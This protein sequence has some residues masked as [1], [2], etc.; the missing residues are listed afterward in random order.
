MERFLSKR[1]IFLA[2]T[3]ILF[4]TAWNRGI[5]LLYLM[6]S[7]LLATLLLGHLLPQMVLG[8]IDVERL[9]PKVAVAGD[10]VRLSF[11][12]RNRG[13]FPRFMVE[14]IDTFPCGEYGKTEPML[15][16]S[17]L[18]PRSEVNRELHIP[19]AVR[20]EYMLGP[21]QVASAFPLGLARRQKTI[22]GHSPRILV[23]PATFPIP[24]IPI[25]P[26]SAKH[27]E[28]GES[29]SIAG[30]SEEFFGIREYR[31]GDSIRMV[32]WPSSARRNQLLV[33]EMEVRVSAQVT[34][35]LDLNTLAHA[36]K[37][38]AHS[39]E[40]VIK[41][42]ASICLHTLERHHQVQLMSYGERLHLS[43][44]RSGKEHLQELMTML[45]KVKIGQMPFLQLI[46][47]AD[48]VMQD[49]Q[50]VILVCSGRSLD[51]LQM[52]QALAL[53]Q[54]KRMQSIVVMV[55]TDGFGG[56]DY[57]NLQTVLTSSTTRFYRMGKDDSFTTL[58]AINGMK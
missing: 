32:H 34:L 2:L 40:Y 29:L 13:F 7:L 17:S 22:A 56:S 16:V 14:V 21:L 30:G 50:S 24:D 57:S 25:K 33:K 44:C 55:E 15:F 37:G 9:A 52:R 3:I 4:L 43:P 12:L 47:R 19:C 38:S 23:Y 45:A 42:A 27:R 46:Q 5:P 53:L 54:A 58:F 36:G 28:A 11:F 35:L 41:I 10:V 26:M 1:I 39:L 6:F 48:A 8:R 20:G 18:S 49:G 31:D 51:S